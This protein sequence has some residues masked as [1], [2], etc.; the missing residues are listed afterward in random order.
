MTFR[1]LRRDSIQKVDPFGPKK[2]KYFVLKFRLDQMLACHYP[3]G[4]NN[5]LSFQQ[6]IN[7][8]IEWVEMGLIQIT[9]VNQIFGDWLMYFGPGEDIDYATRIDDRFQCMNYYADRTLSCTANV[10]E[11]SRNCGYRSMEISLL[12]PYR[13]SLRDVI[14]L[15]RNNGCHSADISSTVTFLRNYV[16]AIPT[17]KTLSMN[18]QEPTGRATLPLSQGKANLELFKK[19]LDQ[20]S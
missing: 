15:S 6:T 20:I 4:W 12:D 8:W 10:Y 11:L 14:E 7:E 5:P 13:I 3:H 16:R 1:R 2:R 9:V 17:G 19:Q 18:V